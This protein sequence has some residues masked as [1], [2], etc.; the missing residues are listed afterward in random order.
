MF[1]MALSKSYLAEIPLLGL[2]LEG[3]LNSLFP[4]LYPLYLSTF[5]NSKRLLIPFSRCLNIFPLDD[6]WKVKISPY[7]SFINCV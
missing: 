4:C 5:L 1:F 7:N 3:S 2:S 6:P